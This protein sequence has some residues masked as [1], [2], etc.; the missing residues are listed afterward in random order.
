MTT[1]NHKTSSHHA[2]FVAAANA[3]PEGDDG[4]ERNGPPR[5]NH[6]TVRPGCTNSE[7]GFLITDGIILAEASNASA[8]AL[9]IASAALARNHQL[10]M[11]LL[12][13]A[14]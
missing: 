6:Q 8:A 14:A 12:M 4:A 3:I 13:H 9:A 10:L 1:K 5:T 7:R 11:S 2:A